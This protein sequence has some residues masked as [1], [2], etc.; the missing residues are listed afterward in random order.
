MNALQRTVGIRP[1]ILALTAVALAPFCAAGQTVPPEPAASSPK[2][3]PVAMNATAFASGEELEYQIRWGLVTAGSATLSAQ[4]QPDAS[5]RP[6]YRFTMLAATTPFLDRIYKVRDR[7]ESWAD[8]GMTAS[9]RYHQSQSEGSYRREL[10]VTFAPDQQQATRTINGEQGSPIS[11]FPGTFD[12]LAAMYAVRI[13]RELAENQTVE[14]PISDGKASVRGRGRILR[15]ESITTPAG[16]FDTW[17]MEPEM[18]DIKGVFEKSKGAKILVWFSRDPRHLPVRISSKVMIG[19]FTAELTAVKPGTNA[20]TLL[21][22][23]PPET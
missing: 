4:R 7:F 10:G 3:P 11:V 6:A 19:W 21:P 18:Y 14:V 17:V 9:L 1:V 8:A 22:P 2:E 23:P 15:A 20:E 16:T 12:P 5:G 13:M